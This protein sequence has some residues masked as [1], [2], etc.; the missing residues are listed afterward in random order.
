MKRGNSKVWNK[1]RKK[2]ERNSKEKE[3]KNRQY[4]NFPARYISMC[5]C[6]CVTC[7]MEEVIRGWMN[8]SGVIQELL[9]IL[10][11]ILLLILLH[12]T[13]KNQSAVPGDTN[14]TNDI[15]N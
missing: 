1:E 12:K 3:R 14:N 13:W 6:V 7:R 15:F 11:G 9:L 8:I 5:V 2:K 4:V 10:T